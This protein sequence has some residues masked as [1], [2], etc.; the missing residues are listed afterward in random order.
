VVAGESADSTIDDDHTLGDEL[1]VVRP[2]RGVRLLR[3][4][5]A[6]D[7]TPLGESSRALQDR[8]L[9]V[10]LLCSGV[11]AGTRFLQHEDR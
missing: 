6:T 5:G 10:D 2:V 8:E 1:R 4:L 9:T 3:T 11:D 7:P